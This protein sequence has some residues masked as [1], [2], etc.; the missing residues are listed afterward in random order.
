MN[1]FRLAA[2]GILSVAALSSFQVA[3]AASLRPEIDGAWWTV[4]TDPDLGELAS[5]AQQP[6]D[7]AIWQAADGTWQ[8]WSCI[9]KTKEAGNTRLLYRWEGK[10]L[11]QT[12][13]T[14][15]GV[16]MRADAKFGETPGGLQAPHV[17]RDGKTYYMLYGD[18]E[19]ICLA[20]S[21]DGK[22]FE[23]HV[24]VSGRT[25][26]FSEGA[27]NNTRDPMLIRIGGLWHCYYTAH[28]NRQGADYC[29]T[30][31]DLV[32][33]SESRAVARGGVAG[34]GPYSAECP[35]V[36]EPEKGQFILFRTQHYGTSALSTFY[37]SSDPLKFGINEDEKYRIGT[38]PVAAPEIVKDGGQY[39]IAA[40]LPNLKGIKVAKL[41]WVP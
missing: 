12:N 10:T 28:L 8:L 36:V 32:H 37:R 41:R 17:V 24:A 16:A 2:A 20:T 14:P 39:Y 25:G 3:S 31:P 40:L 23:R 35:Q 34:D 1:L 33:W 38:L 13:W 15:M 18:W 22:H 11:T 4:A 26:L 21:A 9:R 29:R 6:V 5:H 7:F 27:G 19:N 30:S